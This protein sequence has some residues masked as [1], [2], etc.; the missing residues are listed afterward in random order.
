[1]AGRRWP[2][3]QVR[4]VRTEF[5]PVPIYPPLVRAEPGKPLPFEQ[6]GWGVNKPDAWRRLYGSYWGYVRDF[7]WRACF[8]G[9]GE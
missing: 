1:M 6:Q 4:V 9:G 2:G 7:G 5:G 3:D 8:R